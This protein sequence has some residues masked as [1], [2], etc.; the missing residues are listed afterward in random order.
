LCVCVQNRCRLALLPA[1]LPQ[2]GQDRLRG[3][4]PWT[5]EHPIPSKQ[6]AQHIPPLFL[7]RIRRIHRAIAS[8]THTHTHRWVVRSSDENKLEPFFSI[9]SSQ[10]LPS[11]WPPPSLPSSTPLL[12]S[13]THSIANERTRPQECQYSRKE[14]ETFYRSSHSSVAPDVTVRSNTLPSSPFPLSSPPF[15]SHNNARARFAW[16]E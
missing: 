1:V 3:L 6:P 5:H 2:E 16:D 9:E 7:V 4:E 15:D 13:L 10:N 14:N 12:G 8:H 11:H